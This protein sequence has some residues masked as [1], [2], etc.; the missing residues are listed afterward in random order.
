[1]YKHIHL[2]IGS[3][4]ILLFFDRNQFVKKVALMAKN[5]I[6]HLFDIN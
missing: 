1:M 2:F 5:D 3:V 6:S 4:Q